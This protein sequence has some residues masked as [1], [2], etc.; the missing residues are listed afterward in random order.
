[1]P[2]INTLLYTFLLV[3]SA[4][5]ISLHNKWEFI[6]TAASTV[7][8]NVYDISLMWIQNSSCRVQ[9]QAVDPFLRIDFVPVAVLI[10]VTHYVRQDVTWT[11]SWWALLDNI[12]VKYENRRFVSNRVIIISVYK[13]IFAK[14]TSF[15]LRNPFPN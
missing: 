13:I 14:K 15:L 3:K 12:L 11:L 2:E 4:L 9:E 10:I 8:C 5:Q 1:M 6:V 7:S